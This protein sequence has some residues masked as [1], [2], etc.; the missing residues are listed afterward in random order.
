MKAFHFQTAQVGSISSRVDE[1]VGFRIATGKMQP[2]QL[3]QFFPLQNKN[4]E[5]FIKPHDHDG[6]EDIDVTSEAEEKTPS[7]KL[8]AVLFVWH[9][10]LGVKESFRDFYE[11]QISL[12]I[13]KIKQKLDPES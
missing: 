8:R 1:S 10:Q 7:Q 5:V 13:E 12:L 3:A 9:R 11:R 4:V 2:E 6:S